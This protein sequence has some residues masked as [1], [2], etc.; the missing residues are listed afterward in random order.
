LHFAIAAFPLKAGGIVAGK[1]AL[2]PD[3]RRTVIL[4][5]TVARKLQL[6]EFEQTQTCVLSSSIVIVP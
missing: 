4:W 2:P 3:I 1:L 5:E 6:T